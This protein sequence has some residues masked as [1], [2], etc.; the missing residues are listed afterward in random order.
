MLLTG[1]LEDD[2][3]YRRYFKRAFRAHVESP[4]HA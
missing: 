3:E 4:A 2:E 1:M